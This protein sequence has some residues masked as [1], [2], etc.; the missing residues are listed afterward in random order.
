MRYFRFALLVIGLLLCTCLSA[1]AQ[2]DAPLREMLIRVPA[3]PTNRDLITFTD[4]A[5]IET[6]YAPAERPED[7]AALEAWRN[8]PEDAPEN[9]P[10]LVWWVVFQRLS[11]G[12]SMRYLGI[13]GETPGLVGFDLFEIDQELNYGTPPQDTKQLAGAFDLDTVRSTFEERSYAQAAR[14]DAELWCG[15]VGCEGGLETNLVTRNPANP[16]GG[17]LGRTQPLLIDDNTLISSASADMI[18]EHIAVAQGE[19]RSLGETGEYQAAVNALISDGTLLQ[20]L[21]LGGETL[22]QY[23]TISPATG[24]LSIELS[25]EALAALVQEMVEGYETLPQFS[26][27]AVGD[28]VTETEHQARVILVYGSREDA[29]RAAEVLPGRL[30]TYQS[31]VTRQRLSEMLAD[32]HVEEVRYEVVEDDEA[33][34]TAL[35]ITFA[36]QKAAPEEIILF[37]QIGLD[38]DA[39]PNAPFPGSLFNMVNR[40]V[41]AAD[42]GWLSTVPRSELE[43]MADTFGN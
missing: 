19:R 11:S 24:M 5:A 14:D 26:L 34:R 7:W 25:E 30:D 3:L 37:N 13:A 12:E 35:I 6:A 36:A 27:L 23:T 31:Q 18:E 2:T 40:M 39:L 33:N 29:E 4:F 22:L 38:P 21:F 17:D 42:L 9:L 32:R 41:T 8:A 28:V 20:A 10:F 16:F 15:E 43:A 1:A